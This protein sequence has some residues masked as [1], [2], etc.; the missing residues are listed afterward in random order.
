M[1][2]N[3]VMLRLR[4]SSNDRHRE[5]K[6]RERDA[7]SVSCDVR[8]GI[9]KACRLNIQSVHIQIHTHTS[10]ISYPYIHFICRRTK[11][12]KK[13]FYYTFY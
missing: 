3:Y 11:Y 13:T 10:N 8:N 7:K 6:K 2:S 12:S 4:P 9:F 1:E 5:P